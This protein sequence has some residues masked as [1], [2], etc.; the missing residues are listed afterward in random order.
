M[1]WLGAALLLATAV[2]ALAFALLRQPLRGQGPSRHET[3]TAL[4]RDRLGEL[5]QDL[6]TKAHQRRLAI[7][8]Q[9]L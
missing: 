9:I 1:I 6:A 4:Y 3:T 2:L 7:L 8:C 5:E